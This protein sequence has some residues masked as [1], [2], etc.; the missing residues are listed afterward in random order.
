MDAQ[1]DQVVRVQIFRGLLT[2]NAISVIT[3][4]KYILSS[5]NS[6]DSFSHSFKLSVCSLNGAC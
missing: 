6:G 4:I 1:V 5:I 3:H 2:T